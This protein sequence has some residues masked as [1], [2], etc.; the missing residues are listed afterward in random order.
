[1]IHDSVVLLCEHIK[2]THPHKHT[3]HTNTD[4]T[5]HT[6]TDPSHICTYHTHF[7]MWIVYFILMLFFYCSPNCSANTVS[8][9]QV[10]SF[11][12]RAAR[13]LACTGLRC[14]LQTHHR[15]AVMPTKW[16]TYL[17]AHMLHRLFTFNNIRQIFVIYILEYYMNLK[18][19]R[20]L[21]FNQNPKFLDNLFVRARYWFFFKF[22]YILY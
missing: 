15:A 19:V 3:P 9:E 5:H 8:H 22:Y 18:P 20:F 11:T 13:R 6:H 1:M 16:I 21:D 14:E 10:K 17:L 12:M 4:T 2:D 7:S